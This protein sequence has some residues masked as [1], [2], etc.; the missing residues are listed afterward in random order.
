MSTKIRN[1]VPALSVA[2]CAVVAVAID[3][4]WRWWQ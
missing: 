3:F 2:A 1:A 4:V